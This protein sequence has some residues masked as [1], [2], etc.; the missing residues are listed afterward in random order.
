[1]KLPQLLSRSTASRSVGIAVVAA[2]LLGPLSAQAAASPVTRAAAIRTGSQVPLRTGSLT[3]L[4]RGLHPVGAAGLSG[5]CVLAHG[6]AG[7]GFALT[8]T[9][10]R[11]ALA[12]L[13]PGRYVIEYSS[14]RRPGSYL[15]Q[16]YGGSA[17]R[18]GAATVVIA[19]GRSASLKPVTMRPAS[20][21]ALISA[22]RTILRRAATAHPAAHAQV[23]GVVRSA[24]GKA[25]PNMCAWVVQLTPD[26]ESAFGVSTSSN[27]HYSI[28]SG[29]LAPGN[30]RAAFTNGCRSKA[31]YAPQWW[32]YAA[33]IK[34][35][36]VLKIGRDSK[37]TGIDGKLTAGG[38][39]SGTVRAG[40]SHG[41][42]LG[43]VCVAAFPNGS[44]AQTPS[45]PA[46]ARTSKTGTYQLAG[47]PTGTYQ[48]SFDTDC[49]SGGMSKY[50]D[51]NYPRAVKVR[52]GH[53][54]G[55]V[56]E[57]LAPA[58]AITGTVTAAGGKA[59]A[60]ICALAVSSTGA[61]VAV[62][63]AAGQYATPG[64]PAGRYQVSFQGGCGNKQSYA[65]QVYDNQPYLATTIALGRGRTVTGISAVMQPGATITGLVTS[66]SNAPALGICVQAVTSQILAGDGLTPEGLLLQGAGAGNILAL[67]S[68]SGH[69]RIANLAPGQYAVMFTSCAKAGLRYAAQWFRP[70]VPGDGPA[71]L[72]AP[73]GQPVQADAMLAPAGYITGVIK[74]TSGQPLRGICWQPLGL[75]G[76]V[77]Y[78]DLLPV[79][80]VPPGGSDRQGRYIIGGLAPGRYR[81]QFA[82]CDRQPYAATWYRHASS[83]TSAAT[84]VVRGG[85][86][87]SG[88]NVVMSAGLALTG[89][90]S[91]TV[92]NGPVAFACVAALDLA[93]DIEA[94]TF[95]DRNGSY[96]LKHLLPGKYRLAVFPCTG[97]APVAAEVLPVGITAAVGLGFDVRLP[98]AGT[99]TGKVSGGDP[100]RPAAGICVEA[101]PASGGHGLA[102]LAITGA[103][104]RY[105]I[106]GLATDKYQV[107]FTP[108]CLGGFGTFTPQWF[109]G[110]PTQ[111]QA[112]RVPV[113]SGAATSGIN[114]S[115]AAPGSI[116]GTVQVSGTG[117]GG[118]CV[119]AY[120]AQGAPVLAE[121]AAN[122][123]YQIDGLAAGSYV[124]E[125]T[126]GCGASTYRTQWYNGVSSASEATSVPVTAGTTTSAIDAN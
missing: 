18:S 44:L 36:T 15:D 32:R 80:L 126:D 73:A 81:V 21:G 87:T 25:L 92:T 39:I 26:S 70:G 103:Q 12:D 112:I 115:L 77:P 79:P 102:Q 75:D 124:V 107:L 95:T 78:G 6:P 106:G 105:T 93:G 61:A 35:A 45:L 43:H 125:F 88:V 59:L 118:V 8:T 47:L 94:G 71:L 119:I 82:P 3:G 52:A 67:V 121:T 116:A 74:S 97:H 58:S 48:V 46:F 62:T 31:N 38:V 68:K 1:V 30:Y 40:S 20:T 123:S 89:R 101:M 117:T 50:L 100:A 57:A 49:G 111:T 29:I 76:Q 90:V 11:Y 108:D 7:T 9:G 63:N 53:S 2:S 17:T 4:V 27:G 69:F 120:P 86:T 41:P 96:Q 84:I 34:A 5:I 85:R 55:D 51:A 13:R 104:G 91:S 24:A 114:A 23:S 19:P 109:N 56:D 28:P 113:T 10:G 33:T 64:L 22:S 122:G 65:P 110:K 99:I 42:G 66:Q 72:T 14:C 54:V 98:K 37:L 83:E 16:F 60:G